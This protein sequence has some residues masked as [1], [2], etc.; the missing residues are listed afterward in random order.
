MP[1]GR[2][3]A[4]V[5]GGV[6]LSCTGSVTPTTV[7]LVCDARSPILPDCE[8]VYHAVIHGTISAGTYFMVTTNTVTFE[9][10]GPGC[11]NIPPSC[12]QVNT[13]G[14]R[15]GPPPAK[16]CETPTSPTSWGRIKTIYR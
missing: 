15:I 10:A 2:N 8:A 13:H 14:V 9:G 3:D 7:D 16:Y 12:T 6:P 1:F 5:R 4:E 11:G